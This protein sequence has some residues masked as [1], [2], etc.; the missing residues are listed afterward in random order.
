MICGVMA[1]V[2][3]HRCAG[4]VSTWTT[5]VAT[6]FPLYGGVDVLMEVDVSVVSVN[7]GV[8]VEDQATVSCGYRQVNADS[9]GILLSSTFISNCPS[10]YRPSILA[11]PLATFYSIP[12]SLIPIAFAF[13]RCP[14]LSAQHD[15]YPPISSMERQPSFS[16]QH[17]LSI[18]STA[19]SSCTTT[20]NGGGTNLF[21]VYSSYPSHLN[22][23]SFWI[24]MAGQAYD[25]MIRFYDFGTAECQGTVILAVDVVEHGGAGSAVVGVDFVAGIPVGY[26]VGVPLVICEGSVEV[27]SDGGVPSGEHT[28]QL[29]FLSRD[30]SF[31]DVMEADIFWIRRQTFLLEEPLSYVEVRSPGRPDA[32]VWRAAMEREKVIDLKWYHALTSESILPL[33]MQ[34]TSQ[35]C[36]QYQPQQCLASKGRHCL[37]SAEWKW[38]KS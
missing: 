10:F 11:H 24:C 15:W 3:E 14:S 17:R 33:S 12:T 19:R 16:T 26:D 18:F 2:G 30:T 22:C 32:T 13:S 38:L 6:V 36:H 20:H 31:L 21:V 27:S 28:G 23:T 37:S 5:S 34:S 4:V 35:T 1:A 25:D 7:G 8:L 29:L 9:L